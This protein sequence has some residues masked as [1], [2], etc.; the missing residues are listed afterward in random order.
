MIYLII[1][2]IS[3]AFFSNVLIKSK[4]D[5]IIK[6]FEEHSLNE[7]TFNIDYSNI[8]RVVS[9][10]LVT[11][12]DQSEKL[13]QNKYFN[14]NVTGVVI[15]KKGNILT[16]YSIVKNFEKIFIKLPSEESETFEGNIVIKDENIDLAIINIK[17][18]GE[19]KPIKFANTYSIKEGQGIAVLGN[20]IGDSNIENISPGIIT[21]THEKIVTTDKEFSL[22]QINA[23]IG[24]RNTGG[25][26]SNSNGELIGIASLSLTK[27]NGN[28]GFYYGAN[29]E[30]IESLINS[31][32]VLKNLLGIIE[33]GVLGAD[34]D[35]RGFYVQELDKYGNAYK[36]GIKPTDIIVE[37]DKNEVVTLDDISSILKSKKNGDI[38]N[39]KILSNGEIKAMEIKISD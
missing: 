27:G 6:R 32:N 5:K 25:A 2:G 18:T 36:A 24:I 22:L 17:Y 28:V 3:G 16:N 9:P 10:S 37:M 15:D 13:L 14:N 8:I 1:A 7:G 20:S 34:D 29:L 39:C 19:L 26:I 11:I 21:S 4:Y 30:E 12:G 31:T 38:L 35:F 23:P 33:G